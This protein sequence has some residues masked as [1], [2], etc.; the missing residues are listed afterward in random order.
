MNRVITKFTFVLILTCCSFLGF[1]AKACVCMP[2]R[3]PYREYQDAR[4]V[5]VGK[6]NSSKDVAI[7]NNIRDKIYTA[8]E[9]IFQFSIDESLKG[10]KTTTAEINVGRTESDCYQGFTV[11]KSYLVYAFGDSN[12]SLESGPAIAPLNFR[13]QQPICITSEIYSK[14]FQSREFTVL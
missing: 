14:L 1:E 3:T 6:V 11:G 5:F 8:Y 7:T 13:T 10:L 2:Q 9:R 4:A 12:S